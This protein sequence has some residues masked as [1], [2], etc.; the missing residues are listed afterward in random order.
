MSMRVLQTT[1]AGLCK[2]IQ[3]AILGST[4]HPYLMGLVVRFARYS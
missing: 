4:L 3:E 2:A 1:P